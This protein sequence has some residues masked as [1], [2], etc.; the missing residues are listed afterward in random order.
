MLILTIMTCI[1]FVLFIIDMVVNRF[2]IVKLLQ[3]SNS[4]QSMMRFMSFLNYPLFVWSVIYYLTHFP[5]LRE[6]KYSLYMVC[7]VGM[8]AFFPKLL[9]KIIE[10]IADFKMQ[11]K[12]D[13]T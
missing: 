4:K 9:Q 8:L 2:S 5:I 3:D 12:K 6:S 7:F 1:A 13:E 11:K 10:A